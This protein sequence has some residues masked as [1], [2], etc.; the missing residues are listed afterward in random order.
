MKPTPQ[1]KFALYVR[2]STEEQQNTLAAQEDRERKYVA[3][4]NGIACGPFVDSGVSGSTPFFERPAVGEMLEAMQ[5]EGI[6]DLVMTSLD[7]GFRNTMD[8]LNTFHELQKRGIHIHILNMKLDTRTPQGK[9]FLTVLAAIAE[10]ENGVRSIRQRDVFHQMR[11][12]AKLC[13]NVPYGW[14]YVNG[15]TG[16]PLPVG[17]KTGTLV[18]HPE[19]QRILARLLH[20]D[21]ATLTVNE[22]TRRLNSE[23]IPSP[24]AGKTFSRTDKATGRVK[25][26]TSDGRW[27][28][29][30][31]MSVK[32]NPRLAPG[33]EAGSGTMPAKLAA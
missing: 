20:G 25:T 32:K 1:V 9:F 28:T 15:T 12:T 11:T 24:G 29:G 23:G 17:D 27:S 30:S 7:R 26:W 14:R 21:L 22:A 5:R 10:L 33:Y 8:C 6:T 19:Q 18:P 3:A 2:A 4:D 31:V 13:G 16:Q